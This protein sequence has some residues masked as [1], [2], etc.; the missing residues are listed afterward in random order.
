MALI[1]NIGEFMETQES[2]K[3]YT[4]RMD[5]FFAANDIPNAKRVPVLLAS[6]GPVAF[7]VI[8]NLVAPDSP[9]SKTYADLVAVV[10]AFYNPKP[11]VTVQ[12][13]QFFSRF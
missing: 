2:W 8:G 5:Q 7:R 1:G 10:S 13:Y 6:M 3:Q 9:S 11:I 12:R 4:E